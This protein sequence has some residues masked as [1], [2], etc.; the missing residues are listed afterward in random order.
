MIILA[1][2]NGH[3]F[4]SKDSKIS[5]ISASGSKQGGLYAFDVPT[6]ETCFS[7]YF[8]TADEGCMPQTT[9]SPM[10]KSVPVSSFKRFDFS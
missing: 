8:H 4:L 1:F 7:K 6:V 9:Q 5:Q 2:F 10:G 3:G